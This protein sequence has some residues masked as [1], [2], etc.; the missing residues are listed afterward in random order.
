ML[1]LDV[2]Q[3]A[4]VLELQRPLRKMDADTHG[5]K[6]SCR[7]T[8]GVRERPFAALRHRPGKWFESVLSL[9]S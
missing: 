5:F 4:F 6:P 8:R 2:A 7:N 1:A 3:I 9:L